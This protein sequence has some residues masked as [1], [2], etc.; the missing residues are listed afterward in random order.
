[1]IGS[2]ILNYK[3]ISL[4][5]DGGMGTVYLAEHVK[6]SRKAAIKMLH[7]HLASNEA[8]RMRFENEAKTMSDLLHPNIVRLSD[9]HE[10]QSGLYLI[11]EYIEGRPLDDYIK[12]VSGPIPEEKAIQYFRQALEAFQYAHDKGIVHRDIKPSNL[13]LTND[14][15][16]KVLDFGIAK[17]LGNQSYSLTKT[18]S[19]TGTVYYMSPE[20]VRGQDLD[21]RSDIY[22]LGITLYQM[23]TGFNPYY[24]LTT[25][26]DIYDKIVNVPLS[27]PRLIYPAVSEHM[28]K[29]IR[30]ATHKD[31]TKRFQSCREFAEA[32]D[33]SAVIDL[34]EDAG[35]KTMIDQPGF[36]TATS[37]QGH[38]KERTV[39][40]HSALSKSSN[41]SKIW[42]YWAIP[43]AILLLAGLG[44]AGYY[45]GKEGGGDGGNNAGGDVKKDS[46]NVVVNG[47]P[48]KKEKDKKENVDSSSVKKKRRTKQDPVVVQ[49]PAPPPPPSGNV[50]LVVRGSSVQDLANK[51]RAQSEKLMRGNGY[52]PVNVRF[53]LSRFEFSCE[54]VP[55]YSSFTK[56]GLYFAPAN[57]GWCESC[58]NVLAKNPGSVVL[59]DHSDNSFIYNFIVISE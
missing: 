3:I 42:L 30:K 40:D 43:L 22:S 53:N 26:Y 1:M 20:Q 8:I 37:F 13:I 39:V 10:D 17:L 5:G 32:L 4:I 45:F 27:D 47:Q 11:M 12:N 50:R 21:H 44:Y 55:Q 35:G 54:L 51:L 28:S 25:E 59:G 2:Q 29:V 36:G 7:P 15:Q 6:L 34:S 38:G 23:V 48:D 46:S 18:G 56:I 49:P 9:Y 31:V 57:L 14:G 58:S 16:L 19:L 52:Q 33:P 41:K 24:N